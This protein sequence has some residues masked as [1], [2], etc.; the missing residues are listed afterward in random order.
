MAIQIVQLKRQI[1][2]LRALNE[3]AYHNFHKYRLGEDEADFYEDVKPF[4]DC[5][6]EKLEE[7]VSHI[8]RF[9]ERA[10]PAYVHPQQIDQLAE[11]F[12]MV[13]VTCFQKDTKKKR[14]NEQYKSIEYTLSMVLQAIEE[15][16][17]QE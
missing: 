1:N 8:L 12:E 10:K 7:T 13:S 6:R 3:E 2:E 4:A 17:K 15:E 11:N 16:N 5:V 14:F 9:L